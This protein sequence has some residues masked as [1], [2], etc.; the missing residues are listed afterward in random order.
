MAARRRNSPLRFL[1]ALLVAAAGH[2]LVGTLLIFYGLVQLWNPHSVDGSKSSPAPS[3]SAES[4]GDPLDRPIE[5]QT[6]VDELKEPER[7]SDEELR[8]EEQ[9]KKEEE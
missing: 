8:A 9:K 6:L 2:V 3:A 5:I 4:G 1:V 7:K